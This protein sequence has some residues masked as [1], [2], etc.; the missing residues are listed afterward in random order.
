MLEPHSSQQTFSH[1]RYHSEMKSRRQQLSKNYQKRDAVPFDYNVLLAPRSRNGKK[2]F[3]FWLKL[4]LKE[5]HFHTIGDT[6]HKLW[7]H[8]YLYCC[9]IW[10]GMVFS[11]L[12]F[13]AVYEMCL[14][15][16]NLVRHAVGLP[17]SA[18]VRLSKSLLAYTKT[19]RIRMRRI[20]SS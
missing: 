15:D 14:F 10:N 19:N 17:L 5:R 16:E 11:Q 6:R 3:D 7:S 1:S 4:R 8:L 20:S 12:G 9:C 2:P 13:V 18:V